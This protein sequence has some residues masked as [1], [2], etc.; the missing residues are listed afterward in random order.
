M[1]HPPV[2]L[3]LPGLLRAELR[4]AEEGI[5]RYTEY[6][7]CLKAALGLTASTMDSPHAGEDVGVR[8][9]SHQS[10]VLDARFTPRLQIMAWQAVVI[11][12]SFVLGRLLVAQAAAST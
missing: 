1:L 9:P 6:F 11:A 8:A 10:G 2:A 7:A 12:L 4:N 5:G 3:P